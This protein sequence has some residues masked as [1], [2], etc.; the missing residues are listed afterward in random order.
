MWDL[1]RRNMTFRT[2]RRDLIEENK[3]RALRDGL[4]GQMIDF[5]KEEEVATRQLVREL[6]TLVDEQIDALG[7]RDEVEVIY[8]ILEEGTSADRQVRVYQAHGGDA[9]HEEALRAVV[10]HLVRET[11]EGI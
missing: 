10:D 2:Y 1:R 8:R 9:N 6:L 4:D 7:S 11:A 3:L 5:G